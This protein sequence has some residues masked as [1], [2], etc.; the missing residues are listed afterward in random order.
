MGLNTIFRL[1]FPGERRMLLVLEAADA[2]SQA[3]QA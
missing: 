1:K 3:W 2:I